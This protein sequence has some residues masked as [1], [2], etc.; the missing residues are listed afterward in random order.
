MGKY[1]N[2]SKAELQNFPMWTNLGADVNDSAVSQANTGSGTDKILFQ[3][4]CS[5]QFDLT[6]N[7]SEILL[8]MR[9]AEKLYQPHEFCILFQPDGTLG[10]KVRIPSTNSGGGGGKQKFYPY[11]LICSSFFLL[12]TIVIYTRYSKK[13]LNFYTR[14]VRHF[15]FVLMMCFLMLATTKLWESSLDDE[16][17][18]LAE[19]YPKLCETFGKIF[20]T[21][22]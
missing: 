14:V 6:Q 1:C 9:E 16:N 18:S 13:L 10:A 2:E 8:K 22:F 15:T 17:T 4:K 19:E 11:I 12:L 7:G 21:Q 3:S 20:F 5:Q